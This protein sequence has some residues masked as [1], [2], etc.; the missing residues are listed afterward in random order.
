MKIVGEEL[1]EVM[2]RAWNYEKIWRGTIVVL[3]RCCE[4]HTVVH[5]HVSTFS[6]VNFPAPCCLCNDWLHTCMWIVTVMVDMTAVNCMQNRHRMNPHW[7]SIPPYNLIKIC[8]P[9]LCN[10]LC[11]VV[12]HIFYSKIYEDEYHRM[13]L[14]VRL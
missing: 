10:F 12:R 5:I 6:T 14:N 7:F 13:L 2:Q 9:K 11:N 8:I 1:V 4:K 3:H